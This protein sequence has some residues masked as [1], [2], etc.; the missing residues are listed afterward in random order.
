MCSLGSRS[1]RRE[2]RKNRGGRRS[3]APRTKGRLSRRGL[4]N[5][6]RASKFRRRRYFLGTSSIDRVRK[7]KELSLHYREVLLFAFLILN[8]TFFFFSFS[9]KETIYNDFLISEKKYCEHHQICGNDSYQFFR[10][11]GVSF[12]FLK[13][14]LNKYGTHRK[15]LKNRTHLSFAVSP[16]PHFF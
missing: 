15:I 4:H 12:L 1:W 5:K 11:K 6:G 2:E 10:E 9:S 3:N 14:R 13:R 16:F 8:L 7:S